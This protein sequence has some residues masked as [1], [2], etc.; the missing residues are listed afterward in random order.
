MPGITTPGIGRTVSDDVRARSAAD[1]GFG[2][3]RRA[4]AAIGVAVLFTFGLPGPFATGAHTAD[5][6]ESP[7][8]PAPG[9]L[10]PLELELLE[11]VFSFEPD[12]DIHLE[13][14]LVGDLATTAELVPPGA[15]DATTAPTDESP[16]GNEQGDEQGEPPPPPPALTIQVANYAALDPPGTPERYVGGDVDPEDF[17]DAIDGILVTDLRDRA[18][19]HDDGSVTFTLD[20]P[21]DVVDSQPDKLKFDAPGLY[22]LR[23]QL[24]VGDPAQ[25]DTVATHGTI[26]ERLA[27]PD[28]G[29]RPTEPI[30]LALLA[31]I[32]DPGPLADDATR[33]EADEELTEIA[34][35][36]EA[37]ASP[38]AL[39]LPPSVLTPATANP[40]DRDRLSEQ[41]AD[42]ELLALPAVPF[43]VSSAV[44][45]DKLD[46]FALELRLGEDL[47]TAALPTV[48]SRRDV[49]LASDPLSAAGA[50]ALR[51]LGTRMVVMTPELYRDTIDPDLPATDLFVEIALPDGGSLPLLVVDPLGVEFTG[52]ATTAALERWTTA[53][54]SVATISGLLLDQQAGSTTVQRSR[55]VATP[56]LTAPDPRLIVALERMATTTP[57]LRFAPASALTGVTDVQRDG[58]DPVVVELPS[59]AGPSIVDRVSVLNGTAF[60]MANAASML[61]PDD[62]RPPEWIAALE[63]LVSTGYPESHVEAVVED[64]LAE[65]GELTGAIV[66]PEPFTFTLTGKSGDID[67]RIGNTGDE[68]LNV[69]LRLSS[70]KLTFPEGDQIVLL[71]PNSETSVIVPVRARANG[72]SLVTV[73]LLTPVDQPL[74]EPV[75]VT[76]RVN[77]LTGLGQVLTGGLIIVLLTWW[78]NHWRTRRRRSETA[79]ADMPE[80]GADPDETV[81]TD[82]PTGPAAELPAPGE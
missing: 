53:E 35:S 75:L 57:S 65:A 17:E 58:I 16:P 28:E 30:D 61:D 20:I 37:V 77:A 63:M 9:P 79:D 25:P 41:L 10:D 26:V 34:A 70:P 43:D 62:P 76:S 14:R 50:Q 64:L 71:R 23:V 39:A 7:R 51:D 2:R 31:A 72:T 54:W 78:F 42:D 22:P 68:P 4:A 73:E 33:D 19:F 74:A 60:V 21:T 47:L 13:Y 3:G 80:A 8:Q 29:I 24:R 59:E 82:A 6:S 56:D 15:A 44:A 49:W 67:M 32:D 66:P 38:F 52:P 27:G 69:K 45:A 55:A 36:A 48:P 11:Q 46:A 1:V 12:G 81:L 5:A 18:R 40:T